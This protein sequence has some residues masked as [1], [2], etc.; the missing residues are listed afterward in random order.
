MK[1]IFIQEKGADALKKREQPAAKVKA[2]GSKAKKAAKGRTESP[3]AARKKA[4]KI[5]KYSPK[6][7]DETPKKAGKASAKKSVGKRGSSAMPTPA[8]TKSTKT[9]DLMTMAK[10]KKFLEW[11]DSKKLGK[12]SSGKA[13]TSS[14]KGGRKSK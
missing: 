13:S 1:D 7:E 9:S 10:F 3:G 12:R 6:K 8:G 14:G 2:G 11:H 4:S 5:L